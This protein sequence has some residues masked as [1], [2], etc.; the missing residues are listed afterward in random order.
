CQ[1]DVFRV[2]V[3][4]M[5]FDE[6][7]GGGGVTG[8]PDGGFQCD[9][10]AA[11]QTAHIFGAGHVF[12]AGGVGCH[13]HHPI[14]VLALE[15]GDGRLGVDEA[16]HQYLTAGAGVESGGDAVGG[17]HD[18]RTVTQLGVVDFPGRVAEVEAGNG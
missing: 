18:Q 4:V 6:L 14:E 3:G 16:S 10:F 15:P 11:Q 13:Q 12:V 8:A 5:P 2:Q 9:A 17:A 1:V 7:G